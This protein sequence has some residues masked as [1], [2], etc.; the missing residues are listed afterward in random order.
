MYFAPVPGVSKTEVRADGFVLWNAVVSLR[1]SVSGDRVEGLE[2]QPL[3]FRNV[4]Q[5]RLQPFTLL[6]GD[7]TVLPASTMKFVAAQKIVELTTHPTASRL[8]SGFPAKP[9]SLN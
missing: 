3:N 4:S 2:F 5:E 9:S 6:L 1:A 7:G 8:R